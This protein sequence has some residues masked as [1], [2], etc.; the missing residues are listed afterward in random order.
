MSCLPSN[1]SAFD[2]T[3]INCNI[4]HCHCQ[5]D[6]HNSRIVSFNAFTLCY[7]M[8]NCVQSGIVLYAVVLIG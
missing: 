3:L 4:G 5:F 1:D 6:V 8:M 7:I 2:R